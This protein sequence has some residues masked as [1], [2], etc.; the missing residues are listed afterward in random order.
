MTYFTITDDGKKKTSELIAECRKHFKV[1]SYWDD[2]ELDKHFKAPKEATTR[3]FNKTVESENKGKSRDD[4]EGKPLM[5]FRE[6]VI[7][8]VQHWKETEEHL[9]LEGWTFFQDRLPDGR[10]AYGRWYPGL[11]QVRFRWFRS[12]ARYSDA[13]GREV[14]SLSSSPTCSLEEAIKVCKEAGLVVMKQY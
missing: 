1:S 11:S 5:T 10:V 2:E 14:V 13:G 8:I 6:Y 4:M 7:F 9:D 3:Y 12:G